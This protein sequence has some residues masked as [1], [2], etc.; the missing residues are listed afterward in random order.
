MSQTI[1]W[2]NPEAPPAGAPV[3]AERPALPTAAIRLG[4]LDNS[5]AN[6]DHLLAHFA[7]RTRGL[8]PIKQIVSRR[9]RTAGLPAD[10][11][12]LDELAKEADLV[13]SAMADWGSCTSWSVHDMAELRRR[14]V[15]T[16]VI[17]SEPF[18]KLARNQARIFGV[19]DLPLLL[20]PH[21]LGGLALADVKARAD[22]AIT[23][24]V[25]VISEHPR[26]PTS[27]I[28]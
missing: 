6:A 14:G 20:I 16:A 12:V 18:L 17:C 11:A 1:L 4:L 22:Q 21:P 15:F 10:P 26:W 2:V 9:K 24:L 23:Q 19:P 27:S 28:W 25:A 5:K 8:L 7:E 13:V 3:A